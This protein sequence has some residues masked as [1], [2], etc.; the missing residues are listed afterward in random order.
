[1]AGQGVVVPRA[2]QGLARHGAVRALTAALPSAAVGL[3]A[4]ASHIAD[5]SLLSADAALNSRMQLA[6]YD[7]AEAAVAL[8]ADPEAAAAVTKRAGMDKRRLQDACSVHVGDS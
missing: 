5:V 6:L 8:A 3:D 7:V 1:M 2:A 4:A